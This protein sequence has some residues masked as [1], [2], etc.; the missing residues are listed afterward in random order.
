MFTMYNYYLGYLGYLYGSTGIRGVLVTVLLGLG[1][2]QDGITIFFL[3]RFIRVI[4]PYRDGQSNGII[5]QMSKKTSLFYIEKPLIWC[6][7]LHFRERVPSR[8]G[9]VDDDQCGE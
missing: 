6:A 5:R 7:P 2:Y 3:K 1:N 9:V 4:S 8:A